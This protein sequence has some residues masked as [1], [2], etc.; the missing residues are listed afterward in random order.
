MRVVNWL[1]DWAIVLWWPDCHR[2]QS[3]AF[4]EQSFA[5]IVIRTACNNFFQYGRAVRDL[6]DEKMSDLWIGWGCR[7]SWSACSPHF[8]SGDFFLGGYVKYNVYKTRCNCLIQLKRQKTSTL[9]S[10][11]IE[12]L[13]NVWK[14][15]KNTPFCCNRRNSRTYGNFHVK[16]TIFRPFFAVCKTFVPVTSHSFLKYFPNASGTFGTP[17]IYIS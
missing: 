15:T 12:M 1:C 16:W 11:L 3:S 10:I 14:N 13:Q 9:W 6:L 4:I 8:T 17:C 5:V 7:V 2:Q